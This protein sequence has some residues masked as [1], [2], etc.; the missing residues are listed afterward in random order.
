MAVEIIRNSSGIQKQATA[1]RL[2]YAVAAPG[3][4]IVLPT[5]IFIAWAELNAPG[6][7]NVVIGITPGGNEFFD[8]AVTAGLPYEV[9]KGFKAN[10][11]TLYI[12]TNEDF[13]LTIYKL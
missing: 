12:T 6:N 3:T 10:N 11:V 7:T 9:N 4:N 1:G 8:D 13:E 5:G 2:K